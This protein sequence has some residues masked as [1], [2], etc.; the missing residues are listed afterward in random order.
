MGPIAGVV[1][2]L[3]LFAALRRTRAGWVLRWFAAM[4]CL[5]NG[6]YVGLGWLDVGGDPA[7]MRVLGSP[8]AALLA[9]GVVSTGLGVLLLLEPDR[10]NS[11]KPVVGNTPSD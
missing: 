11:P 8:L 1:V 6:L 5:A 4:A 9:F 2:P 7:D 3:A 10:S